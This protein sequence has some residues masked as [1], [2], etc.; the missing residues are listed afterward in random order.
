[1]ILTA[2]IRNFGE[3]REKSDKKAVDFIRNG[4]SETKKLTLSALF[5]REAG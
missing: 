3:L 5:L 2:K 4:L 1:M